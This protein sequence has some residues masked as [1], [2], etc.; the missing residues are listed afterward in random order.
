MRTD[1]ELREDFASISILQMAVI[2]DRVIAL[3]TVFVPF[4]KNARIMYFH[5][6]LTGFASIVGHY[7]ENIGSDNVV[8]SDMFVVLRVDAVLVKSDGIRINKTAL[9]R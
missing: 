7:F 4:D 5:I 2:S 8:L 1:K 6:E 3:V 9:M